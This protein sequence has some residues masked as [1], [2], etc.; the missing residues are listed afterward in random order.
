MRSDFDNRFNEI[1]T[2]LSE[3]KTLENIQLNINWIDKV[4]EVWS[5]SQMKEAK[6]EIY[7]QKYNS[8][9]NRYNNICP[10][11]HRY[12]DI[13]LESSLEIRGIDFLVYFYYICIN[14]LI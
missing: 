7:R 2:K 9:S 11:N 3:V 12:W 1:N 5:P 6:N 8:R 10:N 4:N 14:Q 13:N